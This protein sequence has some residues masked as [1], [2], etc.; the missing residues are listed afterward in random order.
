MQW[1]NQY[2]KSVL[3]QKGG[4]KVGVISGKTT[5]RT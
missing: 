4:G 3:Q 2:D 5:E 1:D